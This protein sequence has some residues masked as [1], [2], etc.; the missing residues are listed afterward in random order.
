[1]GQVSVS[2]T[3]DSAIADSPPATPAPPPPRPAKRAVTAL[4]LLA[5]AASA[6]VGGNLFGLREQV[7]GP[8]TPPARPAAVSRAADEAA[9][10][11]VTTAPAQETVLRS[12]PWWQE[13]T[14][15]EG[16]GA[17]T[18][19]PFTIDEGAIQWRVTWTCRSGALT[20]QVASGS[21]PMV[22]EACPGEGH[23][24][25]TE[26]GPASLRVEAA[27]PWELRV[28]QQIDVPLVEAPL[29]A[30]TAPGTVVQSTGSFYRIDQSTTGTV[31]I[32]D[33]AEGGHALRLDGFFVPPNIDLE[34]RLSPLEAPRTNEE[35]LAAPSVWVAPLDITAGSMN[36]AVPAEV[37]PAQY[38]SVVIWCPLID[39]AYAA[40]TLVP[41]S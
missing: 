32:Y 29:P 26:T 18:T 10:T 7:L 28:E 19:A 38:R 9:T 1:M 16:D 8:G 36:F 4:G 31:T 41:G 27:G 30:M 14:V 33:L 21:E 35:F 24:Y 39:S 37:D 34:I 23:G 12:Q 2:H 13:V 5:L 17:T 6:V 15:L 22:D 25:S 3:E 20:V 40:A 11:P